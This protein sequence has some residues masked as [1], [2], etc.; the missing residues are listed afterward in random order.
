MYLH[1]QMMELLDGE[2]HFRFWCFLKELFL[3][4][5]LVLNE[6]LLAERMT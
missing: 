1:S 4:Q 3:P 2:G 6:L 5:V